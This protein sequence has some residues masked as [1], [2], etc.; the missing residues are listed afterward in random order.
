MAA[1][2]VR[3]DDALVG[4]EQVV[5]VGVEVGDPADQRRARDDVV[6]VA[7]QVGEQRGVARVTDDESVLG[8]VV[9]RLGDRAVLRV[10][11][12]ADDGIVAGE[13][14]LDDVAADESRRSGDE[15]RLPAHVRLIA[16]DVR[17]A[18]ALCP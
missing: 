8:V 6:A 9:V 18:G 1:S 3:R 4:R 13:Q 14:L 15:H 11:V 5:R 16:R 17:G 2:Q 12:D 10:V 7:G